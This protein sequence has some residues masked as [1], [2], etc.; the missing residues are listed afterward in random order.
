[1]KSSWKG[2]ISFFFLML[3]LPILNLYGQQQIFFEHSYATPYLVNSASIANTPTNQVGVLVQKNFT[4]FPGAPLA[5]AGWVYGKV[6]GDQNVALGMRVNNRSMFGLSATNILFSAAYGLPLGEKSLLKGGMS[7]GLGSQ[8]IDF[9][10]FNIEDPNEVVFTANYQTKSYADGEVALE[11]DFNDKIRLGIA[12]QNI[13]GNK[14]NY[15]DALGQTSGS[16]RFLRHYTISASYKMNL[17]EQ[18]S[19]QEFAFFRSYEGLPG[20]LSFTT[21]ATFSNKIQAGIGFKSGRRVSLLTGY[22]VSD[23][24]KLNYGF[25]V[26]PG[27]N[28]VA[29]FNSSLHEVQVRFLFGKGSDDTKESKEESNVN[30]AYEEVDQLAE[31]NKKM[32]EQLE[33]QKQ[34][35]HAQQNEIDRLKKL[36]EQIASDPAVLQQ[37]RQSQDAMGN[38]SQNGNSNS[39]SNFGPGE[40][41]SFGSDRSEGLDSNSDSNTE[42]DFKNVNAHAPS[43]NKRFYVIAGVFKELENARSFQKVFRREKGKQVFMMEEKA[44]IYY[45]AVDGPM[46]KTN[47]VTLASNLNADEA[48]KALIAGNYWILVK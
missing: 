45:V 34:Q 16:F 29:S 46:T 11:Y 20:W 6:K 42:I 43:G 3:S 41:N 30:A 15:E 7:L 31:Q 23:Q 38:G 24:L 33:K 18:I 21:V 8:H 4:G 40:G 22:A 19:L 26:N 14:L 17:N 47:A 39:N 37:M 28:S 1:M 27:V 32:Q 35:I 12:S 44:G 5:Q 48:A 13:F 10:R 36:M 25:G 9:D 2:I